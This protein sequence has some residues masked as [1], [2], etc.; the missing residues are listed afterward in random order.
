MRLYGSLIS[1]SDSSGPSELDT[2]AS[3]SVGANNY[4]QPQCY[5]KLHIL[6]I[7]LFARKAA[8]ARHALCLIDVVLPRAMTVNEPI[9]R[10][11][12]S[13]SVCIQAISCESALPRSSISYPSWRLDSMGRYRSENLKLLQIVFDCQEHLVGRAISEDALQ[14]NCG[15]RVRKRSRP[16]GKHTILER[17]RASAYG[18]KYLRISPLY[19]STL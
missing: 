17:S 7:S 12:A 15:R 5:T 1:I 13:F 6:R 3:A 19:R 4:R 14:S 2:K 10:V 18:H 11:P 16:A 9:K 8:D